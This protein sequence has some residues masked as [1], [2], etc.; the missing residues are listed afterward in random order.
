MASFVTAGVALVA[1][2]LIWFAT[3]TTGDPQPDLYPTGLRSVIPVENS[4]SPRQGTIGVSLAPGWEPRMWINDTPIPRSQLDAGTVQ[5]G[6]FFFKP[7][8]G[9]AIDDIRPGQ[10]CARIEA[11]PTTDVEAEDFSFAWCWTAF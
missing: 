3:T 1:A 11:S 7:G 6:E 4:Q 9:Q 10:N 8:P 2:G 5:L